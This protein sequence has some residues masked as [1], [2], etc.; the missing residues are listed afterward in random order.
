MKGRRPP[1][2]PTA[3]AQ[4]ELPLLA[5]PAAPDAAAPPSADPAQPD[6]AAPLGPDQRR[7][8][9]GERTLV[10]HLKRSSRRT[11]GFVVDDRGLSITAPRWVTLAEIE[12]AIA[13]KQKWIFAKLAEWHTS[14]ARRVLPPMR[15]EDGATLPFLGKPVMLKLESPIGALVFDAD[16]RTL[17]LGL[18]PTATGQQIKDRVQGWLQTQARR[19]F[20]ERLDVYAE[21]LGVRHSICPV[22]GRDAPGALHGRRQ[23]PAQLAAGAFPAVA[24]RLRG[25]ARAG[26]SQGDEPQPALLGHGGV[27]LSRVPRGAGAI[28]IAS[29]GVLPVF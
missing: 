12:H 25:G 10:Y 20:G 24:D 21:R 14:A 16:M 26:A 11:I 19:L 8:A 22:L 15:W 27:D 9:L 28:A 17:H 13:E 29:A 18:P 3:S 6:P 23:D 7:L 4:L 5:P 1:A 2:S